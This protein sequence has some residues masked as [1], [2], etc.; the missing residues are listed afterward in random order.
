MTNDEPQTVH[1][2]GGKYSTL[3]VTDYS[4]RWQ[5]PGERVAALHIGFAGGPRFHI[6]ATDTVAGADPNAPLDQRHA[7]FVLDRAAAL[8][9]HDYLRHALALDPAS[10]DSSPIDDANSEDDGA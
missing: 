10:E 6:T 2:A 1:G 4:P 5:R 9:L 8:E 7:F 3:S